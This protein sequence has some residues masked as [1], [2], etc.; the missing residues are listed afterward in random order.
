[1][2][3]NDRQSELVIAVIDER[4]EEIYKE[5]NA[6]IK[7]WNRGFSRGSTPDPRT[8]WDAEKLSEDFD[9]LVKKSFSAAELFRTDYSD[10]AGEL[11]N[12]SMVIRREISFSKSF[13]VRKKIIEFI[14]SSSENFLDNSDLVALTT[15]LESNKG[16]QV[17]LYLR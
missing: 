1:M 2:E 7:T 12:L 15:W 9:E 14:L 4:N 17:L 6:K 5:L 13:I 3:Q 16:K 8:R 10:S 11:R